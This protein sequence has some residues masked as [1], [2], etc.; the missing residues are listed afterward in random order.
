MTAGDRN[1]AQIFNGGYHLTVPFYQ[2]SY[3]WG[4]DELQ[5]FL[6]DMVMVSE[7]PRPYF[8]GSVILKVEHHRS[9]EMPGLVV[10]DGQ[11]RLTTLNIFFKVLCLKQGKGIIF[12]R[13]FK[14]MDGDGGGESILLKHN[15]YDR[16]S[17][18]KIV[19][20]TVLDDISAGGDKVAE[21]YNFF[22]DRI[23]DGMAGKINID[24]LLHNIRFVG[25]DLGRDED[26]Q[27]IFDTINSLGIRLATA[28]LLKN[29][30][31]KQEDNNGFFETHWEN[32]FEKDA[33]CKNFWCKEFAVGR[34]FRTAS[35]LFFHA[36][37]QIKTHNRALGVTI[38]D[39]NC[40][41]KVGNL[42]GSYKRF[43]KDYNID[44]IGMIKEIKEYADIF[45]GNFDF[46]IA[47]KELAGD[48]GMGRIN[49]L[50]F[51]LDTTSLI[52]Y[53]LFILR[54]VGDRA[55]RDALFSAI[56]TLV[57]R[58]MVTKGERGGLNKIFTEKLLTSEV[59]T[60]EVF[61]QKTTYIGDHEL[62]KGFMESV[63]TNKQAR[64]VLYM[65]ESKIRD[66]DRHATALKGMG[67]YT[68][69]HLMPKNWQNNWG[70]A[71]GGKVGDRNAKIG[72]LGN[73]AIITQSLNSSIRASAWATKKTG[74]GE[75]GGLVLY[76]GG[77]ETLA[78]YL[79]LDQ[80]GEAQIE[81]R[82]RFLYEKA[83]GVWPIG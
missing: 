60:K 57:M 29:Y 11:Q 53:I 27:E 10:I 26:E 24:K 38:A 69:E 46:C 23:T 4:E 65:I 72:S 28:D 37:L 55:Q 35:D 45:R 36:Y 25:I 22:K 7:R 20:L 64:G 50:I 81:E 75:D 8:L 51:G 18:E 2:R 52:P 82:G 70:S 73:T 9:D 6:D 40:F 67:D 19:D 3:V 58:K 14:K 12:D 80:W 13:R 76:S 21:A 78:P 33:K 74:M 54:H 49:T 68:L 42:F 30:F 5:R 31:F 79:L 47:D 1:V 43:I 48:D 83:V 66:K 59:L 71:P 16:P 61:E 32:V 34:H 39:R 17:F 41:V 63:L 77:M 15:R 44:K 56:E 62:E